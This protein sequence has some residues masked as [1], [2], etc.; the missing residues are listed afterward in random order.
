M[1]WLVKPGFV[2]HHHT[3]STRP[4]KGRKREEDDITESVV[5][6]PDQ[7]VQGQHNDIRDV[8]KKRMAPTLRMLQSGT[9]RQLRSFAA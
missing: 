3:G 4:S 2:L 5:N 9:R 6:E 1:G 7:E 8:G